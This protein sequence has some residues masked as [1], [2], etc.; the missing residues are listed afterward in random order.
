[1]GLDPHSLTGERGPV[2]LPPAE[3]P[4]G[5]LGLEA[6]RASDIDSSHTLQERPS[7]SHLLSGQLS[8]RSAGLTASPLVHA[9]MHMESLAPQVTVLVVLLAYGPWTL[10]FP[11]L[12]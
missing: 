11:C 8:L 6:A 7:W 10:I 12:A 1:M 3:R 5:V 4:G 2:R 9:T